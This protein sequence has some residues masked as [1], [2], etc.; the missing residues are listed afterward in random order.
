MGRRCCPAAHSARSE[1][2][3][4][5][6]LREEAR[7]VRAT[8]RQLAGNFGRLALC[9][10]LSLALVI[11][12]GAQ[13]AN[14]PPA[15]KS[16]M[17]VEAD[18]LVYNKDKNTVAAEGNARAYYEGRILQADRIVYDRNSGRVYAEGH[19]K[20]T[21]P[22]GTILHGARFDLTKDF[23][24]GFI[25]SLRAETAS[26][27]YVSAP[28]TEIIQGN[29]EVYQKGTYTACAVC[30]D[31]PSKPPLWRV[32]AKRIVHKKD[33]KM[34][35][36][37]DAWLEF[38]GIPVMWVPFFSSPDPSVKRKSGV[39]SPKY[40]DMTYAG[41]GVAVPI[42]WAMAPNYDLTFTPA[43][44]LK[45]GF[46]GTLEWR[47]RLANGEYFIRGNGIF[48]EQPNLF[49][50]SPY[51]PGG[52]VLRG[53]FESGGE[54]KI[55]DFWKYGWDFTL[56]TDKWFLSDY[57]VA[58]KTV[59]SNYLSEAISTAYLTG[60]G[61]QGYFDLRG[62]H[63]EGLTA[64]DIQA[65]QPN[66][67]PVLDYNK[68]FNVDP[69]KTNGVGG[70]VT[71][72]FNLTNLSAGLANYQAVGA[73]DLD[74]A[75]G[76]YNVCPSYTPG[77]TTGSCLLRGIG[78][79]YS[80]VTADVSWQR[81]YVD[82]VGEVWTP[83]AF[84]R[85]NGQWLDLNTTNADV[86]TSA[87][88]A[89]I[90]PNAAQTNFV[91][92]GTNGYVV[93]GAGLEYR[94]PILANTDAGSLV[95]EPIG[96][97]IARP[98]NL[99]GAD[100]LVNLDSQSLVFDT[101]NLFTWDKYSGYDRFETGTRA[102]YGGEATFNFKNGGYINVTAGQSVQVAGTNSY[103]SPDAA[104]VGLSSGLDTPWSNYVASLTFVPGP[105][106]SFTTQEQFDQATLQP[107]R[108]DAVTSV[109]LGSWTGSAQFADY[110]S[111]PVLGYYVRR[112]GLALSS[113]YQ[114][115]ANYFVQGNVTFDMSRQFYPPSLIGYNNPG[116]FAIAA[117]GA[118][119]GYQ[120]DCTTVTASYTSVYQDN[121]YG[122]FVHN[123]TLLFE[124]QLR[125]LGDASFKQASY[126]GGSLDG[127]K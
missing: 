71:L 53:N 117:V 82:P 51:G 88:G 48:Q 110:K 76:L 28:H 62:Y 100:T 30:A 66:A 78:G 86:F 108:L 120:N 58:N 77:T 63:F 46:F 29:T 9:L 32:R 59:S 72:D 2:R 91:T 123:Q 35:Y 70:N 45:E 36:Y 64:N 8:A 42:F 109:N 127:I 43:Y 122:T 34:I 126:N 125:T 112:Q 75:Y 113:K 56:L 23:A 39:L 22:D 49:P 69:A 24:N 7:R 11:P 74:K 81:Q 106:I 16:K 50:S 111:Q 61:D 83:F 65:Q 57:N 17:F 21:E 79:D 54:F 90:I 94:Y 13:N 98:N 99:I 80:R 73:Q 121:G 96:Q 67:I 87:S 1:L 12:A 119:A 102:N 107:V 105:L 37:T 103:A 31:D 25:E 97:L 47:H 15:Q 92:S 18:Q 4:V 44:F 20:L 10:A 104:N 114:I 101:T 84:A 14:P 124:I 27:T 89:S 85:V 33:E 60:Q 3:A 118:E 40:L 26:K 55:N 115:N 68:M 5:A 38:V 116:P 52:R 6:R 19:A 93:P 95:V 41:P